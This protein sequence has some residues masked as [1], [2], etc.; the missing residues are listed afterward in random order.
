[1]L[2][3]MNTHEDLYRY[4]RLPFGAPAM[5]QCFMETLLQGL[6]GV[7]MFLHD[8]LAI[9]ST[10]AEHLCNLQEV[11]KSLEEAGMRLKKEK[12]SFLLSRVEYLGHVMG[13]EGLHPS[14]SKVAAVVDTPAPQNV[15][16]LRSLS[17][18]V[19]YYGKFLT[20]VFSI[21]APLCN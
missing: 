2:V 16:E 15:A 10:T 19:N 6:Q 21:L 8:I 11:L 12:C 13:Q 20:N 14:E 5:Y 3:T 18:L 4:K 17:G 7:W 1:M 9:G